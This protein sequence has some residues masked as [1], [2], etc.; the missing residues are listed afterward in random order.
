MSH[1]KDEEFGYDNGKGTWL[2]VVTIIAIILLIIGYTTAHFFP[3]L[4]NWMKGGDP[5]IIQWL[6]EVPKK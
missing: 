2:V 1:H 4:A 5:D 6:R 3:D